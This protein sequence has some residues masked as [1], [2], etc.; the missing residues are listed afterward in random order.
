MLTAMPCTLCT[1]AQENALQCRTGGQL[2]NAL[3]L[4]LVAS[5]G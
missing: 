4:I 5:R 3:K 2:V 1:D